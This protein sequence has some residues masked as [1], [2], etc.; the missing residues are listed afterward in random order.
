MHHVGSV[1]EILSCL[2]S[3]Q[4]KVIFM[5]TATVPTPAW[6]MWHSPQPAASL[7]CLHLIIPLK[8]AEIVPVPPQPSLPDTATDIWFGSNNI[9]SLRHIILPFRS[10]V[11]QVI[12][13]L[14]NVRCLNKIHE[15]YFWLDFQYC[16]Y[17]WH[18]KFIIFF[19]CPPALY[20]NIGYRDI[21]IFFTTLIIKRKASLLFLCSGSY[22]HTYKDVRIILILL[23]LNHS[24]NY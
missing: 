2:V 11:C 16:Y 3:H 6:L 7:C 4:D 12:F 15:I 14:T 20:G 13:C 19:L 9:L 23:T 17:S 18:G 21:T 24:I 1:T 10:N 22:H 5:I 8:V